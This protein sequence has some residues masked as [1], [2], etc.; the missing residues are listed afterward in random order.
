[1]LQWMC[2]ILKKDMCMLAGSFS[3][4]QAKILAVAY[5]FGKPRDIIFSCTGLACNHRSVYI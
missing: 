3:N 5:K 4:P 1:M 2:E